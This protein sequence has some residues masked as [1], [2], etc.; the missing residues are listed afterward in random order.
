MRLTRPGCLC[1]CLQV[2]FAEIRLA[3][4]PLPSCYPNRTVPLPMGNR[5][6]APGIRTRA[7]QP[8]PPNVR[9]LSELPS[10]LVQLIMQLCGTVD[11][12]R[13]ARASTSLF[14][15]AD[16]AAAWK[17]NRFDFSTGASFHPWMITPVPSRLLRHASMHVRRFDP[18]RLLVVAPLV[19]I[20]SIDAAEAF[21]VSIEEWRSLLADPHIRRDLREITLSRH[22]FQPAFDAALLGMIA[23]LPGL[24][25]I[26]LVPSATHDDNSELYMQLAL[27][28]A[29]TRVPLTDTHNRRQ[30][31]RLR[32]LAQCT[33]LRQLDLSA[34]AL[35]GPD[36]R[37]FF[38]DPNLAGLE[39]LSLCLLYCDGRP[40]IVGL[41]PISADDYRDA[42]CALA[43]LRHLKLQRCYGRN[44]LL[45]QLLFSSSLRS[46]H[47]VI[48]FDPFFAEQER[49][50]SAEALAQ[51]MADNA[52]L[53]CAVQLLLSTMSHG[54]SDYR[55]KLSPA[56]AA[57]ATAITSQY[58]H[59]S[60]SLLAPFRSR[61][62]FDIDA[63][64][65]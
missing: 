31:S 45:S 11:L 43:C 30:Q 12:L 57:F 26:H 2:Y 59:V 21:Q 60:D 15:L 19:P 14:H 9:P 35:Y 51:L 42:F 52:E 33:G 55:R 48:E 56:G 41:E 46:L 62:Q 39:S 44:R 16:T 8:L 36:F 23:Q 38:A 34:P 49:M 28:P 58:N 7:E 3:I 54:S 22:T 4:Q 47:L 10:V 18:K 53:K 63:D 65:G 17:F 27:C 5:S 1:V 64:L 37:S 61:F 32:Y 29:L 20:V 13:F 25:S 24:H 6:S 40:G 50:S